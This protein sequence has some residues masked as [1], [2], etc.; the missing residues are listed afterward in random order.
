MIMEEMDGGDKTEIKREMF[1]G[2]M[3]QASAAKKVLFVLFM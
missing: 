3:K 2:G 1:L